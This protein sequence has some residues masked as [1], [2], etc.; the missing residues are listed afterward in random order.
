LLPFQKPSRELFYTG[1]NILTAEGKTTGSH[2]FY[3]TDENTPIISD[4]L[5][6]LKKINGLALLSLWISFCLGLIGLAYLLV[7]GFVQLIKYK[8]HFIKKPVRYS[9][10]AIILLFVPVPF[11][12]LQSF[13]S[14]GD[15]TVASVL[16]AISTFLLPFG[17]ALSGWLYIK[18]GMPKFY[19]KADFLAVVFSFQ[20][21]VV[22][23]Y[24]GLIP[25]LL[26]T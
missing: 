17:L 25:F 20:W 4:G 10:L 22:L 19:G 16:L 9:F 23:A 14:I 3:K 21:V 15:V 12:L 6:S 1:N 18:N 24:W 2:V 7:S 11:F 5:S 26:W 13:V 8:R